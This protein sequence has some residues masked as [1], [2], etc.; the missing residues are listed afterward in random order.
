MPEYTVLTVIAVLATVALELFVFRTGIFTT[1]QY[2]LTMV[3][4]FGFQ[5]LVDGWLTKLSNPIVIYHPEQ[6]LGIRFPWDI[7]IEDYGFGFAMVTLTILGW[8]RLIDRAAVR[9]DAAAAGNG[10]AD[11]APAEGASAGDDTQV[12]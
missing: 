2:W 5:V 4:V 7:P 8:R 10:L 3:I 1:A 9:A 6:M 11:G 12:R